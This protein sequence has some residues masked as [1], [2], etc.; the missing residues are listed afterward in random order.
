ME[1]KIKVNGMSCGHCKDR[2][3]KGLSRLDGVTAVRVDLPSGTVTVEGD[4]S[5]ELLR[6]ALDELGYDYGGKA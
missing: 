3:E 1:M 2:V 4:V 5:E 6:N